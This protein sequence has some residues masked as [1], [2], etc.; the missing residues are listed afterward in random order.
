MKFVFN[1]N[2]VFLCLLIVAINFSLLTVAQEK[3]DLQKDRTANM[4]ILGRSMYQLKTA[5]D[6]ISMKDPAATIATTAKKL[7]NMWPEGSGGSA[8]RAK[9]II[10]AE[11][12]K[13]NTKFLDMENATDKLVSA[14]N[15]TDLRAAKAVFG[16]VG[17]TCKA[18]HK[19]FRGPKK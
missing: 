19:V 14:T 17:R 13:F 1:S 16:E 15:G 12:S 18:C 11:M 10:W 8:T 9:T 2:S 4:K 7:L 6:V 3:S 5:S